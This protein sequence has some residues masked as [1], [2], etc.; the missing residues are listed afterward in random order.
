MERAKYVKKT[1]TIDEFCDGFVAWIAGDEA[2]GQIYCDFGDDGYFFISLDDCHKLDPNYGPESV[3]NDMYGY[4]YDKINLSEKYD[5]LNGDGSTEIT[6]N[7]HEYSYEKST[8]YLWIY[9][10]HP[11]YSIDNYNFDGVNYA[12]LVELGILYPDELEDRH[13]YR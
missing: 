13:G 9:G 7:P 8:G 12:D 6:I 3:C 4:L 1:M 10:K 2:V 5:S 11:N